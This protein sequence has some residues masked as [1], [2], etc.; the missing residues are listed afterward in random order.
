[1]RD[2]IRVKSH[3]TYNGYIVNGNGLSSVAP[4]AAGAFSMTIYGVGKW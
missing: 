2:R 3:Q 1:L 4:A